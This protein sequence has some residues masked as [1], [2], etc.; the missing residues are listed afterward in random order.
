LCEPSRLRQHLGEREVEIAI[1]V[2][3]LRRH[4]V[5]AEPGR[6]PTRSLYRPERRELGLAVEP[7]ARLG[8]ERRRTLAEHPRA[9][10]RDR[11]TK[12]PRTWGPRR[13]DGGED[14]ASGSVQ[15]LVVRAACAERE[16]VHTVATERR[17]RVAVDEARNRAQPAAVDLEDIAVEGREI[18]HCPDGLD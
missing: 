7:V 16:L 1:G 10:Q 5:G 15:L 18:S 2:V 6:N 3:E 12:T 9:M 8:L 13:A 14:A 4:C 17:M 11:R